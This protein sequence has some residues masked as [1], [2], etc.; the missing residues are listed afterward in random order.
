MTRYETSIHGSSDPE[1]GLSRFLVSVSGSGLHILRQG[2]VLGLLVSWDLYLLVR[3]L[4][5]GLSLGW[6]STSFQ[7]CTP[8]VPQP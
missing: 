3:P 2:C 4:G 6:D 7:V 5:G 8:L 1:A